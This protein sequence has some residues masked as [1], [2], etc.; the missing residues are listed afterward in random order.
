VRVLGVGVQ[1][2]GL[3]TVGRRGHGT[4]GSQIAGP[5]PGLA[6][7]VG[8]TG[9]EGGDALL[10]LLERGEVGVLRAA[11]PFGALG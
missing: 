9:R 5:F 2:G 4:W 3:L 8:G 7:D 6:G 11:S 10:A 1:G